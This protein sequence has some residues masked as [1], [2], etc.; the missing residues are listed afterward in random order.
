MKNG[1]D[2]EE[3][4]SSKSALKQ[5]K[6]AKNGAWRQVFMVCTGSG[7]GGSV[8]TED[9]LSQVVGG[10]EEMKVVKEKMLSIY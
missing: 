8:Q 3:E 4:V 7:I 5:Y 10:Q 2:W 1:E 6:L 9:W